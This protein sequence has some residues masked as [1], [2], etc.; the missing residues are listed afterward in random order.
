M[1]KWI[2]VKRVEG[3][4]LKVEGNTLKVKGK[5]INLIKKEKVKS[6]LLKGNSYKQSVLNAGYSPNSAINAWRL[7]VV[8]CCLKEIEDEIKGEISVKDV[9]KQ[10]ESIRLLAIQKGD[11]STAAFCSTQ[12]GKY[13]AMFTDKSEVKADISTQEKQ[14]LNDYITNRLTGKL[15]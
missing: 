6:N 4:T 11:L 8:K 15:T 9:L 10:L 1:D 2:K 13:L 7:G 12:L 14:E 5:R 3:N